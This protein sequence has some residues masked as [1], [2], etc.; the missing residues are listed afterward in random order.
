[1]IV[2]DTFFD[3][4][5]KQMLNITIVMFEGTTIRRG[6]AEQ[7][8]FIRKIMRVDFKGRIYILITNS[9]TSNK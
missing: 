8:T 4:C 2:G 5:K 9:F 3:E 7:C 1:M 6:I